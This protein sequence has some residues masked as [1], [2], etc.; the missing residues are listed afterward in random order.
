MA[1]RRDPRFDYSPP[2]LE[3]LGTL[4]ELTQAEPDSTHYDPVEQ[5]KPRIN[6]TEES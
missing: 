3:R 4:V 6:K 1:C 5:Y 2:R